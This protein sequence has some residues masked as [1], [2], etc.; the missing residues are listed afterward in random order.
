MHRWLTVLCVILPLGACYTLPSKAEF[1][2]A[3]SDEKANDDAAVG[4]GAAG[5]DATDEDVADTI[6][7]DLADAI[8][9]DA[10][11][12]TAAADAADGDATPLDVAD[13][14]QVDAVQVDA[15]QD[16]DST[17]EDA[18]ATTSDGIAGPPAA[19]RVRAVAG[20]WPRAAGQPWGVVGASWAA[21]TY[22]ATSD[23]VYGGWLA[24]LRTWLPGGF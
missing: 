6:G 20:A 17:A 22:S 23:S 18:D 13:T 3:T 15:A 8:A 12:D 21:G 2:F 5:T 9:A 4:D 14:V 7:A 19:F 10:Q 16:S 11:T 24:W 1:R